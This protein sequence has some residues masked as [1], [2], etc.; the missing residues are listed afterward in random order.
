VSKTSLVAVCVLLA[1]QPLAG[2]EILH[3][4]TGLPGTGTA[5]N[6]KFSWYNDGQE[7][8]V[9]HVEIRDAASGKERAEFVATGK[10]NKYKDKTVFIGWKSRLD[11]PAATGATWCVIMQGFAAGQRDI[12]HPFD[13][14]VDHGKLYLVRWT[15]QGNDH[16]T[17][18]WSRATPSRNT[19]FSIVMKVR[20][21]TSAST[22]YI[23]LWYNGARQTFANGSQ[24]M[25]MQTWDGVDNNIH[26]GIYRSGGVNGTGHHYMKNVR[27]ATTYNEAVP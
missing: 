27:V 9:L 24:T 5:P 2:A 22:G 17:T 18:I 20:Y 4:T 8:R 21:S 3:Q 26:W 19:W 11:M 6:G 15:G 12:V 13:L 23:E 7:G 25:K 10:N 14:R 16:R 1:F